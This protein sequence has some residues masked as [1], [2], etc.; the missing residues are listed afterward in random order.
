MSLTADD[1]IGKSVLFDLG[2]HTADGVCIETEQF[3]ADVV[4]VD[5]ESITVRQR[6]TRANRVLPFDP[7]WFEPAEP[8]TYKLFRTGEIVV[9]PDYLARIEFEQQLE[10]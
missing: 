9:A 2:F 4:A 10:G 8:K 5:G 1:L 3:A 6:S 7:E